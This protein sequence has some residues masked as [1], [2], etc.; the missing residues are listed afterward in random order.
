MR[1]IVAI[2]IG[3]YLALG[4]NAAA[5]AKSQKACEI[6]CSRYTNGQKNTSMYA[7]CMATCLQK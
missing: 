2:V 5:E 6:G 7:K 4:L 1:K 3:V